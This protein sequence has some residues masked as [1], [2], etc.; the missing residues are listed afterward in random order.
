M[1]CEINDWQHYIDLVYIEAVRRNEFNQFLYVLEAA[2]GSRRSDSVTS[3][4]EPLNLLL[5]VLDNRI[6]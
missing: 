1:H 2:V 6:F 4:H 3:N 5:N